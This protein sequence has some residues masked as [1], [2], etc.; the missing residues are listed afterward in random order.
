MRRVFGTLLDTLGASLFGN[1]LLRKGIVR[2]GDGAV[3]ADDGESALERIFNTTSSFEKLWNTKVL[4][5]N[6]PKF[7]GV[8]SRNNLAD[9]VKDGAYVVIFDGYKSIGIN[10]IALSVNDNK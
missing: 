1:M 3:Q 10:W 7:K 6:E 9:T 5:Q 2:A 8:Y 4:Y